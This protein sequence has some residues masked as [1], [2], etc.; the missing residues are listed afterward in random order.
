MATSAVPSMMHSA[1]RRSE[2]S[3][4]PEKAGKFC[5]GADLKEHGAG[6]RSESEKRD[7][8]RMDQ[9]ICLRLQTMD[10]PCVAVVYG[11]ALCAGA[12]IALSN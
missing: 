8:A 12:E 1:I 2:R 9:Q 3:C 11:Y 6:S 5:A 4:W 10:K 7:Y